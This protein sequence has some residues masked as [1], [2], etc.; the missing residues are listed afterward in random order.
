MARRIPDLAAANPVIMG[1]LEYVL[2]K[3]DDQIL[4]GEE[5]SI[6]ITL[7]SPKSAPRAL[8]AALTPFTDPAYDDCELWDELVWLSRDY[9]CFKIKEPARRPSGSA[10]WQGV[11]LFFEDSC[12]AMIR[13]WL[14][15]PRPHRVDPEWQAAL[16]R[17][18]TRFENPEAFPPGGLELDAGFDGYEQLLA[19]W[20]RLGEELAHSGGMSWRQLSARCFFGDSKYLD[21]DGHQALARALFPELC[22]RV[23]ERSLLMHLYLPSQSERV[24][25]VENQ[26]SFLMLADCQPKATALVY[27]EG[28]RGGAARVRLPG[29]ARF[30]T[31][32]DIAE[33]ARREFIRWWQGQAE[34][35]LP[36]YFW[37]D[38]D[39]E[40]MQIAAALRRSF[41]SLDCWRPGYAPMLERLCSG[42]GHRPLQAKKNRQRA[43]E[44]TGCD[45]ADTE[46][47]PALWHTGCYVDQESVTPEEL[48]AA[49]AKVDF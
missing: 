16:T 31:L 4:S 39:Y 21:A 5:K 44:S 7:G 48:H 46:L 23:Q 34:Q 8:R 26:D 20:A 14:D 30:S 3:R 2:D 11:R 47:I 1:L 49:A 43:I 15:R 27:I 10:P 19:C 13:E 37:G 9:R 12:E 29:V 25:M 40:G 28:Y 38:L 41:T 33:P 22:E 6:A 17:F 35:E 24:V 42:G 36:A 32:N 18:A 45:Y